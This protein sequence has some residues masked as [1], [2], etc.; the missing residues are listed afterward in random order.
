[1]GVDQDRQ[2]DRRRQRPLPLL[3]ALAGVA[4]EAAL[5]VQVAPAQVQHLAAPA[6]GEQVGQ[7]Q[8]AQAQAGRGLDGNRS[9]EPGH[10]LGA[11]PPGPGIGL[12][13]RGPNP[14]RGVV[15]TQAFGTGP[16]VEAAQAGQLGGLGGAGER[17]LKVSPASAPVSGQKG[18]Q[19]S[20]LRRQGIQ[21]EAEQPLQGV[22][23]GAGGALAGGE[24]EVA[25]EVGEGQL[26][27]GN[28]LSRL[29]LPAGI[30]DLAWRWWLE[31]DEGWVWP[32][33][34]RHCSRSH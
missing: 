1:L 9:Q 7:D 31:G 25:S 6:A 14:F 5:Q 22:Q 21:P 29:P 27:R 24:L 2:P 12:P 16:A 13:A 34:R 11:Q 17:P 32:L 33:Q 4:V 19:L 26:V 10:L 8:G 20:T 28:Q 15:L 3:A 23:V 18:L 30:P